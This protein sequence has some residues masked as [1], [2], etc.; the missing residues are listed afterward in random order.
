MTNHWSITVLWPISSLQQTQKVG[1]WWYTQVVTTVVK[2]NCNSVVWQFHRCNK[3]SAQ[4]LLDAF[5]T[6]Y[7]PHNSIRWT[8]LELFEKFTQLPSQTV[9]AYAATIEYLAVR[10][11]KGDADVKDQFVV[12]LWPTIKIYVMPK[13]PASFADA[14][15]LDRQASILPENVSSIIVQ[16]TGVSQENYLQQ[17]INTIQ[18][19]QQEIID[20]S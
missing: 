3:N 15:N 7:E 16:A 17:Q 12:G 6:R 13:A 14:Y 1:S 9:E 10:F 19:G 18:E 2:R 4:K 8:N 20:W 5:K 11:D